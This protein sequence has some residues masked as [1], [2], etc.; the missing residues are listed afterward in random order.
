MIQVPGGSAAAT[1]RYMRV[2]PGKSYMNV[3][4]FVDQVPPIPILIAYND[5]DTTLNIDA[6]AFEALHQRLPTSETMR[7]PG[8]G[9]LFDWPNTF[10]FWN[11]MLD[12]LEVNF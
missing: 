4:D 9:H 8:H 11:K 2:V 6:A 12:W 7:L 10:F 5:F 1:A 3:M